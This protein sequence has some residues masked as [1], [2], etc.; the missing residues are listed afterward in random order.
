MTDVKITIQVDAAKRGI[1]VKDIDLDLSR[2][3]LS[4]KIGNAIVDGVWEELEG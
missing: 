1:L 2:R 4:L 3:D